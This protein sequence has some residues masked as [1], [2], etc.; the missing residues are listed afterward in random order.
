[1][2]GKGTKTKYLFLIIN[3]NI[4]PTHPRLNK[5]HG[6][7]AYSHVILSQFVKNIV[8]IFIYPNCNSNIYCLLTMLPGSV[9]STFPAIPELILNNNSIKW[10]LLSSPPFIDIEVEAQV[11]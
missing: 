1:M 5:S 6:I 9:L 2:P 11:N 8:T 10:L 3:H 7:H 4:I